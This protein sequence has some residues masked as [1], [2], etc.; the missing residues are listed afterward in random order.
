MPTKP[1][2]CFW[3]AV[4]FREYVHIYIYT[5]ICITQT[6]FIVIMYQL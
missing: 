5:N 6:G 1:Y 2:F 4:S 3:R